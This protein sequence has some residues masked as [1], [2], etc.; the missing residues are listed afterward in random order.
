MH[1][2]VL[3][4]TVPHCDS[5]L[6]PF[7]FTA[8]DW[9]GLPAATSCTSAGDAVTGALSSCSVALGLCGR[10][11]ELIRLFIFC[12][13]QQFKDYKNSKQAPQPYRRGQTSG[14]KSM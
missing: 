5:P 7:L 8:P 11:P 4:P 14:S 2:T 10:E 9:K 13:Q 1:P 6:R 12:L 3:S